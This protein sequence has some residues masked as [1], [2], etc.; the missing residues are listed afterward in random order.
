[1]TFR[2]VELNSSYKILPSLPQSDLS[3][4]EN[5]VLKK[6]YE[7]QEAQLSSNKHL[8]ENSWL[9]H[10][11]PLKQ[12]DVEISWDLFALF[13]GDAFIGEVPIGR[14]DN[15]YQAA[16]YISEILK[17]QSQNL[18]GLELSTLELLNL[19]TYSR[20]LDS[21][22]EII[23]KYNHLRRVLAREGITENER[24]EN[25][26]ITASALLEK[27]KQARSGWLPFGWVNSTTQSHF[28]LA[29]I[30][31]DR[32]TFITMG[33][34]SSFH[35]PII[36]FRENR[37][38]DAKIVDPIDQ[39]YR[40][41]CFK[42]LANVNEEA[43][44]S[45][46]F[47]ETLLE[48]NT[49][50]AWD[51]NFHADEHNIFEGI[52]KLLG[53]IFLEP[54]SQEK[55][56]DLYVKNSRGP[57][58]TGKVL[59]RGMH[60]HF[61]KLFSEG[62]P[63]INLG[64]EFY[65]LQ[66]LLI[67]SHLLVS[68]CMKHLRNGS[69]ERLTYINAKF[70]GDIVN[71]L[72][73]EQKKLYLRGKEEN[74]F[75]VGL[76]ATLNDIDARLKQYENEILDIQRKI[77]MTPAS[78]AIENSVEQKNLITF[79]A[80]EISTY[81]NVS[82]V[83]C[84]YVTSEI[85]EVQ[86]N[87]SPLIG[88]S[89]TTL[90]DLEKL[91]K[92]IST[93]YVTFTDTAS[94]LNQDLE[95]LNY[96]DRQAWL[97]L[98]RDV[99]LELIVNLPSVVSIQG[100]EAS[101]NFWEHISPDQCPVI[102]Q[103]IYSLM[104]TIL[105]FDSRII[106]PH[107]QHDAKGL[108]A[109]NSCLAI[110][111][112]LARLDP[113]NRLEG[114]P[115][116]AVQSFLS[117]IKAAD[118]LVM[119]ERWHNKLKELVYYFT[120][121]ESQRKLSI[122]SEKWS[123]WN[124]DFTEWLMKA[125]QVN[126]VE[127]AQKELGSLFAVGLPANENGSPIIDE[128]LLLPSK[129]LWWGGKLQDDSLYKDPTL[130]FYRRFLSQGGDAEH[131]LLHQIAHIVQESPDST[132]RLLPKQVH[133]LRQACWLAQLYARPNAL[134]RNVMLSRAVQ[135]NIHLKLVEKTSV[136]LCY[137]IE[138]YL[139]DVLLSPSTAVAGKYLV[140][141]IREDQFAVRHKFKELVNKRSSS[142]EIIYTSTAIE[143]LDLDLV[144]A[145]RFCACNGYDNLNSAIKLAE[146]R[147]DLLRQGAFRDWIRRELFR[148]GRLPTQLKNI[149]LYGNELKEFFNKALIECKEVGDWISW[150]SIAYWMVELQV[151]Y[152][153]T[154]WG[155]GDFPDVRTELLANLKN[156]KLSLRLFLKNAQVLLV[157]NKPKYIREGFTKAFLET[158]TEEYFILKIV[159]ALGAEKE[160][161]SEVNSELRAE[162]EA[163]SS[164]IQGPCI[165][166]FKN[167]GMEYR[168]ALLNRLLLISKVEIT[169]SSWSGEYPAYN[170]GKN[171]IDLSTGEISENSGE[172][173]SDLP[174]WV[175][176]ENS[177]IEVTGGKYKSIHRDSF[178][179]F[180]IYPHEIM[181]KINNRQITYVSQ[182]EDDRSRTVNIPF[183][184]REL[185]PA[186]FT[187][188]AICWLYEGESP[189]IVIKRQQQIILSVKL[190]KWEKPADCS[191]GH[192]EELEKQV[193]LEFRKVQ[194]VEGLGK[195]QKLTRQSSILKRA[196][197]A[198]KDE[199]FYHIREVI[200][201]DGKIYV[202]PQ[203]L[204]A[205]ISLLAIF[206][207]KME[208]IVCW[209]NPDS[210]SIAEV[211]IESIGIRFHVIDGT[212]KLYFHGTNTYHLCIE[213]EIPQ[214]PVG[215]HYLVL[216]EGN[217]YRVKL[218][219]VILHK[220]IKSDG[221]LQKI[222]VRQQLSTIDAWIDLELSRGVLQGRTTE[223][224]LYL[225]YLQAISNAYEEALDGLNQLLP[226]KNFS[227]NELK[228]ILWVQNL[229]KS[230]I[231]RCHP[232]ALVLL[233]RLILLQRRDA[234]K[235]KVNPLTFISAVEVAGIYKTYLKMQSN[236]LEHKLRVSEEK[237]FLKFL[238]EL[239]ENENSTS[240]AKA[241]SLQDPNER[242]HYK[243][244]DLLWDQLGWTRSVSLNEYQLF[245]D[246]K[247]RW[248]YLNG[249]EVEVGAQVPT[250]LPEL[251]LDFNKDSK[252]NISSFQLAEVLQTGS[253]YTAKGGALSYYIYSSDKMFKDN[254][255][256][257]YRV[258]LMG[259][260]GE[261]KRLETLLKVNTH[262]KYY[263]E[264][265]PYRNLLY[266]LMQSNATLPNVESIFRVL[267]S[268]LK[269]AAKFQ[270]LKGIAE[271]ILLAGKV[272]FKLWKE[273]SKFV[274]TLVILGGTWITS[275]LES[276]VKPSENTFPPAVSQVSLNWKTKNLNDVEKYF[277]KVCENLLEQYFDRNF[278]E[279]PVQPLFDPSTV[280][281]LALKAR[282][283]ALNN[284]IKLYRAEVGRTP[285]F[286][287]KSEQDVDECKDAI[288]KICIRLKSLLQ[289]QAVI[290][291]WKAN[292]TKQRSDK[293][294]LFDRNYGTG[295]RIKVTWNDL[296]VLF[297]RNDPAFFQQLTY[298]NL[299]QAA[300][301]ME[302]YALLLVNIRHLS[303]LEV[304]L[305]FLRLAKVPGE[306]MEVIKV[307]H[308]QVGDVLAAPC[309]YTHSVE[310]RDLLLVEAS[311]GSFL[312][313]I[314]GETSQL[315]LI[316]AAGAS[317]SRDISIKSQT[318][319]GK[320]DYLSKLIARRAM[321]KGLVIQTVPDT[322]EMVSSLQTQKLLNSYFGRKTDR[323]EFDA[324]RII[325]PHSVQFDYDEFV[326]HLAN[327]TMPNM[328][329]YS[330]QMFEVYFIWTA[331]KASKSIP[332]ANTKAI[333]AGFI[334]QL[335]L[336]SQSTN[337][338]DEPDRQTPLD[339]VI[340]AY[341]TPQRISD[342]H[343]ELIDCVVEALIDPQMGPLV[344]IQQNQ[345]P[346]LHESDFQNIVIP[347]VVEFVL[348]RLNIEP[349][350]AD[351]FRGFVTGKRKSP[352]W[353][354][355]H[356]Q[357]E[358]I[359]LL[360]GLLTEQLGS[361]LEG[362]VDN[363]YGLYKLHFNTKKF[364]GPY[365]TTN[366]PKEKDTGPSQYFNY[367]STFL[368]TLIT[369][370]VNGL[371]VDQTIKTFSILKESVAKALA[372]GKTTEDIKDYN[373][374][375]ELIG[376]PDLKLADLTEQ[377]VRELHPLV[378]LNPFFIRTYVKVL[379]AEQISFFNQ[380]IISTPSNHRS[381]FKK[382][383]GFTATPLPIIQQGPKAEI[384]EVEG[385]EGGSTHLMLKWGADPEGIKIVPDGSPQELSKVTCAIVNNDPKARQI[386]DAGGQF[387]GLK[388]VD[389]A[390]ELASNGQKC[391]SIIFFNESSQ[392]FELKDVRTQAVLH[393][394]EDILD[395]EKYLV[396]LDRARSFATNIE[397]VLD[398]ITYVLLDFKMTKDALD[399]AQG[400]T[401]R[402]KPHQRK[403]KLLLQYSQ[404]KI[405]FG[406]PDIKN[407]YE[408]LIYFMQNQQD[409][410]FYLNYLSQ[411]QLL[412]NLLRRPLICLMLGA[413]P[414]QLAKG[415]LEF[416][417]DVDV[418]KTL[419]LARAFEKVLVT[420]V[421]GKAEDTYGKFIDL[422][423]A[424]RELV[425]DK[426]AVQ[427][428]LMTLKAV[429]ADLKAHIN[430]NVEE[431]ADSWKI[432]SIGRQLEGY[433]KGSQ[434][435]GTELK[436][437]EEFHQESKM[438]KQDVVLEK[439]ILRNAT[440]WDPNFNYH[441]LGWER[442]LKLQGIAITIEKY[443]SRLFEDWLQ[444]LD[445]FDAWLKAKEN[446]STFHKFVFKPLRVLPIIAYAFTMLGLLFGQLAS[447][448]LGQNQLLATRIFRQKDILENYI[449]E[450]YNPILKNKNSNL[451]VTNNFM[452][453][454]PV[455][456][457][458]RRQLPRSD[459]D[460]PLQI[461]L[462]IY[463]ETTFYGNRI[464][465][466]LLSPE[467]A[468]F[469]QNY[470]MKHQ[471]SGQEYKKRSL[472]LYDIRNNRISCSGKFRLSVEMLH[473]H[474]DFN[475]QILDAKLDYGITKFTEDEKTR[476]ANLSSV[477]SDEPP[478][479]PISHYAESNML[480][481]YL[482][483][484]VHKNCPKKQQ[485][486][487]EL[488]KKIPRVLQQL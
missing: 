369:Y 57:T 406:Q 478:R 324:G 237:A 285:S 217:S 270:S 195:W 21:I 113:E 405:I 29:R 337:I 83:K 50:H 366:T 290:I 432:P 367:D 440:Q 115:G 189:R 62:N 42:T 343:V 436:A 126:S 461:A 191:K 139:D 185:L 299:S 151:Y 372:E 266:A 38:R 229:L 87:L 322:H 85:D 437:H 259:E 317:S 39:D 24:T 164:H 281:D 403:S 388:N 401:F 33:A 330:Q 471:V 88:I 390:N 376:N 160:V 331:L 293:S 137:E 233:I 445:K 450:K 448:A 360:Y 361:A 241:G 20:E 4:V 344:K 199:P 134:S 379:V 350:F 479:E 79:P 84:S 456:W 269:D 142:N 306:S 243:F 55:Y 249:H 318:G 99:Y 268:T 345:H 220:S 267:D 271:K 469:F 123:V 482:V 480:K 484:F 65:K 234:Y 412:E 152:D 49:R 391:E 262:L 245:N 9:N 466:I 67:H 102:F 305:N 394:G 194:S 209:K 22:M 272:K 125:E 430:Q 6:A 46:E 298:L 363:D 15:A 284:E 392:V 212:D 91:F 238:Q 232:Q 184:I 373:N 226:L 105:Q 488:F 147:L 265:S 181:V 23:E 95:A 287:F 368:R 296:Q 156:H 486:I 358:S 213:K 203:S 3:V 71:N 30:E 389:I 43:L 279:E 247:R 101:K 411:K 130:I 264:G 254:F 56:P 75:F 143:D 215:M 216:K 222:E 465:T 207:P 106:N 182:K 408:L 280:K 340:I 278:F 136:P 404:A 428:K 409:K 356:P 312:R 274:D 333:L 475:D 198:D 2:I 100:G 446:L 170:N 135:K 200:R 192:I 166:F 485:E 98:T 328:T 53:G 121:D 59:M 246:F 256:Y 12:V 424:L 172:I 80:L 97:K 58:C 165:E 196:L 476:I 96:E 283:E 155:G 34:G 320:S 282:I 108:I 252:K 302:E 341:G 421:S 51:R 205:L 468:E 111:D 169:N 31:D 300:K 248:L 122:N 118:F 13:A 438:V 193:K 127:A 179:N 158:V 335:R 463:D 310:N 19:E 457:G 94:K 16:K 355:T 453:Q 319:S 230:N 183:E 315:T 400:R 427:K 153:S 387:K 190:E 435:I 362:Y 393:I 439:H 375:K 294:N 374:I 407:I 128:N 223:Q 334:K 60:L 107:H 186:Y 214:L 458:E 168:D 206:E 386:I 288:E 295:R 423:P 124:L 175:K 429:P 44:Y 258:I 425:S 145:V 382:T 224:K 116:I 236:L 149:P 26:K 82:R 202:M 178:N 275:Q 452:R 110:L 378:R 398:A 66:K 27:F 349:E 197:N 470:L 73:D 150:F 242:V 162:A 422:I 45:M 146:S 70:I 117:D 148:A 472:C 10:G 419:S 338:I 286:T 90:G 1:M 72:R 441:T 273:I 447:Y 451:L 314:F 171:T 352:A 291:L 346:M 396:Y 176:S 131:S 443:A 211:E 251:M 301:L 347:Y 210:N 364:A 467:E 8:D 431:L 255:L 263:P 351:E 159:Q 402:D 54:L 326:E 380:M 353:L 32:F 231:K 235:F 426:E 414:E 276:T 342:E 63:E 455:V 112:V 177:F 348:N 17:A 307:L 289:T 399:Q 86:S 141:S 208:K 221:G 157:L 201:P 76:T 462:V 14:V 225:I 132:D 329:H 103:N 28:L 309:L 37:V 365:L 187:Q 93:L 7:I 417:D 321:E 180:I 434:E 174:E 36:D 163:F 323:F 316:E 481:E 459:E 5:L 89:F 74:S 483:D 78:P 133:D 52:P 188:D 339:M 47:F 433:V 240:N 311:Q 449:E 308:S 64:T 313:V 336:W 77:V 304:C 454:Y 416:E 384:F 140:D 418:S 219:L 442:P 40:F 464:Q 332:S 460:K 129:V 260:A 359:Y 41:Q 474:S 397:L 167:A 68:I 420:T 487:S 371:D 92:A 325:N 81:S 154:R 327:G 204:P 69:F 138:S 173:K 35:N 250:K 218:P 381:M 303:R 354:A 377:D 370:L 119:N 357:K 161:N 277:K 114:A 48:L 413:K 385:I 144:K 261:K 227:E 257:F 11:H 410:R 253:R 120:Q 18:A 383:I 244:T 109:I 395:P 297:D 292:Q 25:I 228:I 239:M 444:S 61:T 477:I 104:R 415:V 473:N